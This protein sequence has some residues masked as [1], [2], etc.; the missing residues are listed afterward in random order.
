MSRHIIT[1]D[2]LADFIEK[3]WAAGVRVDL[4]PAKGYIQVYD[5]SFRSEFVD[6]VDTNNYDSMV[7]SLIESM[8]DKESQN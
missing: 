2:K 7:G 6:V 1:R 5:P 3:M 8:S 4:S